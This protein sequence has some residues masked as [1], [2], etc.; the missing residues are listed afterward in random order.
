MERYVEQLLEDIEEAMDNVPQPV[1]PVLIDQ[2][3]YPLVHLY[4]LE[5][6]PFYKLSELF[7]LET[8]QFPPADRLTPGQ[9]TRLCDALY[10]LFEEYHLLFDFPSKAPDELLYNVMVAELNKEHII[11]SDGD[12]IINCFGEEPEE[13]AMK[14][15]CNCL[16]YDMEI[17]EEDAKFLMSE[18]EEDTQDYINRLINGQKDFPS[19]YEDDDSLPF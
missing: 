12:T 6:N 7:G 2:E 13:C 10:G 9:L 11:L 16:H 14:E 1:N 3:R 5:N 19:E 8:I 18:E 15:Y 17:D 4:E